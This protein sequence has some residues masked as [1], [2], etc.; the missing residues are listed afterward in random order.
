[1]TGQDLPELG[2]SRRGCPFGLRLRFGR[3]VYAY[4]NLEV[5][6]IS[7]HKNAESENQKQPELLRRHFR[8]LLWMAI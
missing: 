7:D 6:S 2:I 5:A 4:E 3:S 8:S 1:M